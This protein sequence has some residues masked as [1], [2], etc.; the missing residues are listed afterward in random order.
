MKEK[1]KKQAQWDMKEERKKFRR[2]E[3]KKQGMKAKKKSVSYWWPIYTKIEVT[4]HVFVKLPKIKFHENPFSRS[5]VITC[6]QTDG[7]SDFNRRSAG[8]WT[9]PKREENN[10]GTKK[11]VE[12]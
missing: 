1:R 6:V 12:K 11:G 2:E 4:R 10:R 8:M 5:P 3:K 7:L 9:E